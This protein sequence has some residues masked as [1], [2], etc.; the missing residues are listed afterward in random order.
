MSFDK[1]TELTA[2]QDQWSSIPHEIINKNFKVNLYTAVCTVGSKIYMH[3]GVNT[4]GHTTDEFFE[5]ELTTMRYH[6]VVV[7]GSLIPVRRNRH[8]LL[9]DSLEQSLY[10][11]GGRGSDHRAWKFN[12]RSRMWTILS[13]EPPDFYNSSI[14]GTDCAAVSVP[15]YLIVAGSIDGDSSEYLIYTKSNNTWI[16]LNESS[17]LTAVEDPALIS[18]GDQVYLLGGSTNTQY[19]PNRSAV[20][21]I[22]ERFWDIGWKELTGPSGEE[23]QAFSIGEILGVMGNPGGKGELAPVNGVALVNITEG[24]NWTTITQGSS[25]LPSIR[26]IRVVS[27]GKKVIVLGGLIDGNHYSNDVW[28]L[29]PFQCPDQCS[30]RGSC[31]LGSCECI[32]GVS[33]VTCNIKHDTMDITPIVLGSSIGGFV[34]MLIAAFVVWKMTSKMREYRKL[35]STSRLAEDMAA[36]IARMELESLEYLMVIENPSNVQQSFQTIISSLLMYRS[37]LPETLLQVDTEG[38]ESSSDSEPKSPLVPSS[39]STDDVVLGGT[40]S[41]RELV[42]ITIRDVAVLHISISSNADI[43]ESPINN[44]QQSHHQFSEPSYKSLIDTIHTSVQGNRGSILRLDGDAVI[45]GWNF[46]LVRATP[47][48]HAMTTAFQIESCASSTFELRHSVTKRIGHCGTLGGSKLKSPV[49]MGP[50][51]QIINSMQRIGSRRNLNMLTDLRE[52]SSSYCLK[53]VDVISICGYVSCSG[54][55]GEG[56]KYI[57]VYTVVAYCRKDKER[58]VNEWMYELNAIGTHNEKVF[59]VMEVFRNSGP[60]ETLAFIEGLPE[61][62]KPQLHLLKD[63]CEALEM[64]KL[65]FYDDAI[66]SSNST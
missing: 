65:Q 27:Y 46:N 22:S 39:K 34:L 9:H 10:L 29:D 44:I 33:G 36:Q 61:N 53:P 1:F 5:L 64:P 11:L 51:F 32:S 58:N 30:G 60:E 37:F 66:N 23:F 42:K 40:C 18:Y 20:I 4:S 43:Q 15:G 35:Y 48:V 56:G 54:P 52:L 8:F 17:R 55:I 28:V 26:D 13:S 31:K 14:E 6:P 7:V 25:W 47:A 2:G 3:G 38:S 12:L 41:M 50:H 59:K 16:R 57:D 63:T 62:D 24:G 49:L 45:A 21:N 19:L